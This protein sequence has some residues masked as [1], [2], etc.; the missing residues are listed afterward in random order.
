MYEPIRLG[1]TLAR[2]AAAGLCVVALAALAPADAPPPANAK[3]AYRDLQLTVHIRRA[4]RE[5]EALASVNVGVRV[6]DGVAVLWGPAPSAEVIAKAVARAAQVQGIFSVRNELYVTAPDRNLDPIPIPLI[7]PD[8]QRSASASPDPASG[9]L[10]SL[11][12]TAREALDA[13]TAND[14]ST[15]TSSPPAS[16]APLPDE[17]TAD[18]SPR[19]RPVSRPASTP[20]EVLAAAV[21]R[22]RAGEPRFRTLR[23]DVRGGTVVVAGSADREEDV[24]AL[25]RLIS[26]LPG[27]DRV[28][29]KTADASAP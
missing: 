19:A 3:D 15:T 28:V 24:M 25:A 7:A 26:R 5:E 18:H 23:I 14:S 20:P 29:T 4:L 11:T 9:S 22:V 16:H 8:P 2:L 27:V 12:T 1:R 13:G 6:R 21:A 17:Q 10:S